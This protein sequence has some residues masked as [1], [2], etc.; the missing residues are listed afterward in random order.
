MQLKESSCDVHRCFYTALDALLL[1]LDLWETQR[2]V[3]KALR[4]INAAML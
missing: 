2:V 3:S 4:S 1:L